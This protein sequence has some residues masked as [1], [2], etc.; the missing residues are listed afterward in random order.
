MSTRSLLLIALL[1]G[2]CKPAVEVH[3]AAGA[4]PL[5]EQPSALLGLAD[6]DPALQL[7]AIERIDREWQPRYVPALLEYISLGIVP[8]LQHRAMEVLRKRT[9]EDFTLDP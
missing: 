5:P 2:A 3:T 6:A 1:L 8:A 4:A 9:T 7:G